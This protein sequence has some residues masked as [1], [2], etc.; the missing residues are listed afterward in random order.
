MRKM[1]R[2]PLFLMTLT[3]FIDF[4]GFGIILPLLPFGLRGLGQVLSVSAWFSPSMP[5]HSFSLRP[6]SEPFLIGMVADRSSSLLSL[7]KRSHWR[8]PHLPVHCPSCWWHAS[9]AAWALRI[10]A[11]HRRSSLT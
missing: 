6:S 4:A 2:S 10:S 5:W 3:L 9:S 7:S 8:S 11:R 1:V